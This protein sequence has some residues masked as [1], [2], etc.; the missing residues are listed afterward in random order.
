MFDAAIDSIRFTP[1]KS[2]KVSPEEAFIFRVFL[3]LQKLVELAFVSGVS[4]RKLV[5]HVYIELVAEEKENRGE[6]EHF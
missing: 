3:R 4:L 5:E 6:S 1:A 2:A